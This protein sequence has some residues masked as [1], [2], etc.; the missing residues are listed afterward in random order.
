MEES[1]KSV[2]SPASYTQ[3]EAKNL[4]Q[5]TEWLRRESYVP[6][7]PN[8]WCSH[9]SIQMKKD[10]SLRVYIDPRPHNKVLQRELY[11]L[12][13]ME[14]VLP[15]MSKAIVEIS[16]CGIVYYH[17]ELMLVQKSSKEN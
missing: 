8:E 5:V 12:P 9:I 15:E 17:S 6:Q 13:T 4:A 3:T 16:T 10:G 1:T 7:E 14:E 11:P 2:Q